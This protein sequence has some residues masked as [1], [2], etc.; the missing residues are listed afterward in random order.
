MNRKFGGV[1]T[2]PTTSAGRTRLPT[3][4]LGVGLPQAENH[5]ECAPN[6]GL[7]LPLL[8]RR[9]AGRRALAVAML[10]PNS[11]LTTAKDF[12]MGRG[13]LLWLLGVPIPVILLLALCTHH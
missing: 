13:I 8:E 12:I 9:A 4:G 3:P 7:D 10:V 6:V 5:G 1:R 2:L 11:S